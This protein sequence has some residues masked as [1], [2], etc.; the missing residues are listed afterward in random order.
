MVSRRHASSTSFEESIYLGN[1]IVG[2]KKTA[3]ACRTL[4]STD[5]AMSTFETQG[6]DK[7]DRQQLA[8]RVEC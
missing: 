1:A 3:D 2:E 7:E 5:R 6:E 8:K 4:P